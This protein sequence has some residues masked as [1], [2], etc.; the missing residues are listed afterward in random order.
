M[1][2]EQWL[3]DTDPERWLYSERVQGR[4]ARKLRLFCVACCRR[5][6]SLL[7]DDCRLAVETAEDYADDRAS[8]DALLSATEVARRLASS[9][10][11]NAQDA[12]DAVA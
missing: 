4:S 10:D 6:W 2:E 5:I 8:D 3:T 11:G 7:P 12:A 1:T 9:T